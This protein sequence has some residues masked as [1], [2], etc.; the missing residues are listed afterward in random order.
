MQ[1]SVDTF[2]LNLD[3]YRYFMAYT[4]SSIAMVPFGKKVVV[5]RLN[6]RKITNDSGPQI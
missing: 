4:V 6:E 3:K 2:C 5:V 1:V